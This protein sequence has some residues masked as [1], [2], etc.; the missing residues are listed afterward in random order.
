[1]PIKHVLQIVALTLMAVQSTTT[2]VAA[3]PQTE[4]STSQVSSL[5]ASDM[6]G[7]DVRQSAFDRLGYDSGLWRSEYLAEQTDDDDADHPLVPASGGTQSTTPMTGVSNYSR[8]VMLGSSIYSDHL[9][10][11]PI[12]IPVVMRTSGLRAIGESEA[13]PAT[14]MSDWE[15]AAA[16][17]TGSTT[18]GFTRSGPSV[19]SV[20]VG[21]VGIVIVIGAYA[22]SGTRKQ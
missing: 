1:M 16:A 8:D 14:T 9:A 21:F 13:Q 5:T 12:D 20:I 18:L 22:S 19:I 11:I 6:S 15:H 3:M 10:M 2:G 4:P 7:G 17:A